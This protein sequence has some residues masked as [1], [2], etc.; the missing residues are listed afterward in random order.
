MLTN[1][2][3]KILLL[4][5]IIFTA[6]FSF[7]S[8][9]EEFD[10][11]FNIQSDDY[12]KKLKTDKIEMKGYII[13]F[14]FNKYYI[15][16][17][18]KLGNMNLKINEYKYTTTLNYSNKS[19]DIFNLEAEGSTPC[20]DVDLSNLCISAFTIGNITDN[21]LERILINLSGYPDTH[22]DIDFNVY[23]LEN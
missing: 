17:N 14:P 11:A 23:P 1:K 7:A 2:L 21:S 12:S 3:Y 8:N 13:E 18:I 15:K 10:L 22:E 5:I 9:K 20:E 4:T 19:R 16:G 6:F